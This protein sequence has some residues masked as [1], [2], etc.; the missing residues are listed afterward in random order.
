MA[1]YRLNE[2][3][4]QMKAP[5][6]VSASL[7]A[8]LFMLQG[9]QRAHQIAPMFFYNWPS[10]CAACKHS[11]K[12]V[13]HLGADRI[14]KPL[15]YITR[16]PSTVRKKK[17]GRRKEGRREREKKPVS[18]THLNILCLSHLFGMKHHWPEVNSQR[19]TRFHMSPHADFRD[20]YYPKNLAC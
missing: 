16:A 11:A 15:A 8:G 17:G 2:L 19:F 20:A 4:F 12:C 3:I 18:Q 5:R 1:G 13:N 7:H 6:F 10:E 14:V 9:E